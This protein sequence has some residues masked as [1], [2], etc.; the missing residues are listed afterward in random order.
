V[1]IHTFML[2][3]G[4][5]GFFLAGAATAEERSTKG[6]VT[7][8]DAAQSMITVR[9]DTS[10]DRRTY[11]LGPKA[12][13]RDGRGPIRLTELRRGQSVTLIY[14]ATDRGRQLAD[15]Q[16]SGT[17]PT[18]LPSVNTEIRMLQGEITGVRPIARTLTVRQNN[19]ERI[20]V[21]VAEDANVYKDG[22]TVHLRQL[23]KGD[24]VNAKYRITERGPELV[25]SA[26][27]QMVEVLSNGSRQTDLPMKE[28][29]KTA[30]NHYAY[31]LIGMFALG[32][33]VLL[34]RPRRR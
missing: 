20:T 4:V 8:V 19:R 3:V 32:L 34:R 14:Q 33:G 28:L 22:R 9:D 31:L 21:R 5:I 11:F 18:S 17:E 15:V 25:A 23:S 29:P 2:L 10:G 16:R 13:I 30:S 27:T 6:V 1:S 12:T 26:P 24:L 7:Y